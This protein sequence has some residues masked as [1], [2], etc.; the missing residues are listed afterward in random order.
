MRR[1]QPHAAGRIGEE[2]DSNYGVGMILGVGRKMESGRSA[3]IRKDERKKM[4]S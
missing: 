2:R 4:S 3:L 1:I